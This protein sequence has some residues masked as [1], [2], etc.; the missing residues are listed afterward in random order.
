MFGI[1]LVK[2]LPYFNWIFDQNRYPYLDGNLNVHM[3]GTT[4]KKIT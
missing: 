4:V 3:I 1:K 2:I